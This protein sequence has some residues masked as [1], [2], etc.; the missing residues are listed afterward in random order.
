[1]NQKW[2][3]AY[4]LESKE[5]N[6]YIHCIRYEKLFFKRKIGCKHFYLKKI[7]GNKVFNLNQR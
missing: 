2:H 5:I 4:H 6:T 1:M 3:M 7:V